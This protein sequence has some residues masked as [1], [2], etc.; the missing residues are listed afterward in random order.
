MGVASPKLAGK[1]K[2]ERTFEASALIW[3]E[4]QKLAK[5]GNPQGNYQQ[6]KE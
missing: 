1:E 6:G 4:D 3:R 2:P 5:T